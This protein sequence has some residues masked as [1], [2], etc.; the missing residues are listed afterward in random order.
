MK[1]RKSWTL[2]QQAEFLEKLAKLLEKGYNL[3]NALE[4][5]KYYQTKKIRADIGCGIT[6]LKRGGEFHT[7]LKAWGFSPYVTSYIYTAEQQ[8]DFLFSLRYGSRWLNHLH[9]SQA[10]LLNMLRYPIFLLFL[11]AG[12]VYFMQFMLFPQFEYLYASMN[13][14]LPPLTRFLLQLPS[15]MK[16]TALTIIT[17]LVLSFL[18]YRFFL[19]PL[20]VIRQI[21]FWMRIPL[22][23]RVLSLFL[24]H[25][26]MLQFS[27]LLNGGISI[28]SSLEIFSNQPYSRFL[29]E[30]AEEMKKHLRDGMFLT[31]IVEQTSYFEKDAA[32]VIHHGQAN[33][34]IGKELE[35]YSELVFEQME[36]IINRVFQVVQ[37]ILFTVIGL[38]VIMIYL[39]MMLPIFGLMQAI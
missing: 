12:M 23:K 13:Q 9:H 22:L 36:Q 24:T 28:Y 7:V 31:N 8:G 14:K 1:R 39:G 33:G 16:W 20:P 5:L 18:C 6:K 38:A 26:Y 21:K 19:R 29:C 4:L 17:L 30:A 27:N 25:Q 10:R 34:I 2:K 15:M 3:S 35:D 37:P 11:L 32:I